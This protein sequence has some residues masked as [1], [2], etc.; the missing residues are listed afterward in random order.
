MTELTAYLRRNANELLHQV[1]P[2]SGHIRKAIPV[3]Q[4]RALLIE[5]RMENDCELHIHF[6]NGAEPED[7]AAAV[8]YVSEWFD[9]SRDLEPFYRLAEADPILRH[10]VPAY[11]GLR[12]V[13]APDLFE[14][15][16]WAIM[17]QQVS[18]HVAYLLKKRFVEAFGVRLASADGNGS[19]WLYPTAERVAAASEEELLALKFTVRKA[20]YTIGVARLIAS[21]DLSKDEL[22][23]PPN[24]QTIV[25]RL[26]AIRGIGAWS[27]HYVMMRCLRLPNAFPIADVGLHNA[28]KHV[29]GMDR[30]PSIDEITQWSMGWAGWEAYATFYLWRALMNE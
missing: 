9:L 19:Y 13:G 18:L 10:V 30:K 14:A 23:N 2:A 11:R 20:E 24:H 28:I 22:L 1:D 16:S 3:G 6:P 21:G 17:G 4:G 27:A 7:R 5:V 25:N 26:T 8:G 15:M 29:M 12:I